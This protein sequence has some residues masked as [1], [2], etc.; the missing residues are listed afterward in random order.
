M[1]PSDLIKGPVAALKLPRSNALLILYLKTI[2]DA[3]AASAA[4]QNATSPTL[5][6]FLADIGAFEV[7]ETQAGTKAKGTSKAR[8]AA[9]RKAVLD[10]RHLCS[11]V[12]GVADSQ[13]SAADAEAVITA[14]GMTVKARASRNKPPL[15]ARNASVAGTVLLIAK[16]V[17]DEA[18]YFWQFSTDQRTWSSTPET[19]KASTVISGLTSGQTYYFRFRAI[20][21]AGHVDYSQVVSLLVH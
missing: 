11:F 5:T 18:T 9:K 17:A 20:A 12:Q 21:R 19:M 16:A 10:A 2:H 3:M 7:C 15:E 8:N 1:K 6:Q 4:L 14:G 13:P